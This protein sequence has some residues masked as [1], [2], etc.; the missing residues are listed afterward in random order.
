MSLVDAFMNKFECHTI[1]PMWLFQLYWN[2]LK[3]IHSF[4]ILYISELPVL[5]LKRQL[6]CQFKMLLNVEKCFRL[7]SAKVSFLFNINQEWSQV[8]LGQTQIT[9]ALLIT[10]SNES[11]FSSSGEK[12]KD[13]LEMRHREEGHVLRKLGR[14]WKGDSSEIDLK[15]CWETVWY[16]LLTEKV[17]FMEREA[18]WHG[19]KGHHLLTRRVCLRL[20]AWFKPPWQQISILLKHHWQMHWNPTS[21]RDTVF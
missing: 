1:E 9:E 13:G 20:K 21:P 12:K 17:G 7:Q 5:F 10:D 14:K 19:G 15:K 6:A 3:N 2:A 16:A 8:V 18:D 4:I 11:D